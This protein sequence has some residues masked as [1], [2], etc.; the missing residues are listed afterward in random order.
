MDKIKTFT[1][2]PFDEDEPPLKIA[3]SD[4][5]GN[6][7]FSLA[8]LRGHYAVAKAVLEIAQAQWAPKDKENARYRMAGT[9]DDSSYESDSD[10]GDEPEIHKDIIDKQL[11][12]DN[13]GAVSTQV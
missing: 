8:L 7:P 10:S 3:V 11:T 5:K 13:V 2:A 4:S 9:E 1:L 6:N 12:I